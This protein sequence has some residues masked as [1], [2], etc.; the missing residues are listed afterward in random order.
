[1]LKQTLIITSAVLAT[2]LILSG[3]SV[4]DDDARGHGLSNAQEA[5][6]T[7]GMQGRCNAA[8]HQN[9]TLSGCADDP[10]P[11]PPPTTDPPPD[12]PPPTTEPPPIPPPT[13]EPPPP[14][15]LGC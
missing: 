1:M 6:G 7:H 13:T 9:I 4:A 3:V 15:C 5:A 11:P 12:L 8:S 2:A 14:T 10:L